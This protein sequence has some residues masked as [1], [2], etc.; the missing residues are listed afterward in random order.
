MNR[1]GRISTTQ[2]RAAPTTTIVSMSKP[3]VEQ[4]FVHIT[5]FLAFDEIPTINFGMEEYDV[6]PRSWGMKLVIEPFNDE[7]KIGFPS[8]DCDGE[9]DYVI[10]KDLVRTLKAAFINTKKQYLETTR[11]PDISTDLRKAIKALIKIMNQTLRTW[12]K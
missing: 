12:P 7:W 4:V 3:T 6:I 8:D 9:E 1:R 10:G 11:S 2:W 5:Q